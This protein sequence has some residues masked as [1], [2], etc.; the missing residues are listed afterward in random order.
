MS[1]DRFLLDPFG[2]PLSSVEMELLDYPEGNYLTSAVPP[3]RQIF[4]HGASVLNRCYPSKDSASIE[5]L[6]GED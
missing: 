5:G 2:L 6:S 3:P 1:V 4:I